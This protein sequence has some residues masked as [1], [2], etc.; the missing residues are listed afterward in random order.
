MKSKYEIKKKSADLIELK[1]ILAAINV[2]HLFDV[3]ITNYKITYETIAFR[4]K[5][6]DFL[7]LIFHMQKLIFFRYRG[8][9]FNLPLCDNLR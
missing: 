5:W 1:N 9:S 2:S 7:F 4:Q 3:C 8:F 6:Y